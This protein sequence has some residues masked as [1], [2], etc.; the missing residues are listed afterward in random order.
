MPTPKRVEGKIIM[1]EMQPIHEGNKVDVNVL[2]AIQKYGEGLF[3]QFNPR[4]V[5]RW[6]D[7]FRE[8]FSTRYSRKTGQMEQALK[9]KLKYYSFNYLL[10]LSIR[11]S[12]RA[13][14][15]HLSWAGYT[16]RM[17]RKK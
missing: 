4:M 8:I 7:Q 10:F 14:R 17:E 12:G 13:G 16:S 3:F 2:P 1:E 15:L 11:F 5:E 9:D 6:Q